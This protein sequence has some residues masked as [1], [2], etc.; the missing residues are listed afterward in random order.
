MALVKCQDCGKEV[1]SAAVAC[2]NCGFPIAATTGAAAATAA[3]N[4]TPKVLVEQTSKDIKGNLMLGGLIVFVGG[5]ILIFSLV[6]GSLVG[7]LI[8]GAVTIWGFLMKWG[9]SFKRWTEHG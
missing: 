2:P 8:G 4:E 1:S 3:P 6:G 7:A 9:V 5:V